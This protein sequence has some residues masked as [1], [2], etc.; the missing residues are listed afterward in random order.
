MGFFKEHSSN[1]PEIINEIKK[2]ELELEN[3]VNKYRFFL[4]TFL[5]F[6]D[7]AM[8][9]V[10]NIFEFKFILMGLPP[11]VLVYFVL[12]RI[13]RITKSKKPKHAVK[14]ITIALD[15]LFMTMAIFEMQHYM[16]E[17]IGVSVKQVL[18]M[19]TMLLMIINSLSALRIQ[20]HVIG[21]S[22]LIAIILNSYIH[23]HFGS[24]LIIIINTNTFL[25]ITGFF[26]QYI[27]HFI[28]KF[29][30]SDYRLKEAMD[31]VKQANEEITTQ[32]DELETQNDYLAKQRDQILYQKGQITSSIEYASRIQDAVMDS[33][34]EI[35]EVA[36]DSFVVF[37]PK[38]I[39][40]GDFYWFKNIEVFAKNYNVF[41]AVDCTGHGVPGAF[42]S[43]LGISFLNEIIG[44]FYSELN[45]AEILNRLREEVKK[46]LHQEERDNMIK[47]GMD[48][49]ICAIDYEDMKLQYAGANNP[50]YII[51][52]IDSK[53]AEVI[54][55]YKPDKMPIGIYIKEKES[56]TNN[57]IDI[58]KGDLLYL[59]SDGYV[60]Q[61]GG[62][63]GEKFKKRRFRELLLSVCHLPMAE[64]KEQLELT[65]K[66]WMGD[67]FD[68]IDDITVLGVKI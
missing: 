16:P 49:A 1:S 21:I 9:L 47:D 19:G 42:M 48:M 12:Y 54:E 22:T 34:S 62:E 7:I 14:Y 33:T 52:N 57:I 45:T 10:L 27:S 64:Q 53:P 66:K 55:E 58:N 24:N 39:V 38:N 50:L 20:K 56:F 60:D 23:N 65:L 41:T 25:L 18:L 2:G 36:P 67:K 40:S 37:H 4:I 59:F 15:Y 29:Y 3:L 5:M 61:F 26:N 43:M 8:S 46:Y 51:R 17:I 13:H 31:N 28:Y 30:E 68:Q 44:E 6:G 63:R 32:N 11:L 35:N